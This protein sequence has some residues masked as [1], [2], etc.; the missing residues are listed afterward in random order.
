MIGVQKRF[1]A[2]VR[3]RQ[4]CFQGLACHGFDAIRGFPQAAK[5]GEMVDPLHERH[6]DQGDDEDG[7]HKE[8][9]PPPFA[10]QAH[11]QHDQSHDAE[12]ERADEVGQH[13]LLV[14]V[15]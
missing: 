2:Q 3:L 9:D 13:G 11:L 10:V 4:A 12:E 15:M 8:D 6:H 1:S 14:W 5:P 7:G